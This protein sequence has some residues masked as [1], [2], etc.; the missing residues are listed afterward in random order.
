[1]INKSHSGLPYRECIIE[2]APKREDVSKDVRR[3]SKKEIEEEVARYRQYIISH[4]LGKKMSVIMTILG[5]MV[6]GLFA[7]MFLLPLILTFTN[8][9]M[10]P[11][12]ITADYGSIFSTSSYGGKV[13]VSKTVELKFIPDRV[14]LSQYFTVL[15]KSP[16]YLEK[17]WNSMI[18][19]VPIVVFQLIAASMASY[20]FAKY[21]SK[22]KN[23]LFFFYTI[24]M[25]MPYQV[26]L[27]P[28]YLVANFFHLV[29]SSWAIWLPGIFSP[30]AVYLLTKY[31]RRIPKAIF[32]AARIDGAGEW[33]VYRQIVLPLCKGALASA[34]ILIFIDYWNMVEQ[35]LILLTDEYKYPLSVF[36]S[37]INQGEI[38]LAFAVAV[39]YMVPPL[40]VFLYGEE[41]LVNG[42]VYQGGVKG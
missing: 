26:T 9:F 8:S 14:T 38:S 13:F 39:I 3:Y 33:Q 41:Y 11:E 36:L 12:E 32:D 31:I 4:R 2:R 34:A 30:F 19:T 22:R 37:Q 28:N 6:C 20:G 29:D 25:M 24:I 1:M 18:Y 23:V 10:G 35:P 40:L 7:V 21:P 27:V 17:F 16:E 42:I 15:L 5:T